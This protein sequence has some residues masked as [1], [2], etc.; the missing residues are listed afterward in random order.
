MCQN[1]P[2]SNKLKLTHMC[3]PKLSLVLIPAAVYNNKM[4]CVNF[5]LNSTEQYST[6]QY[7]AVQ[8]SAMNLGHLQLH[9]IVSLPGTTKTITLHDETQ[10]Q[11]HCHYNKHKN[12]SAKLTWLQT[13]ISWKDNDYKVLEFRYYRPYLRLPGRSRRWTAIPRPCQ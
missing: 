7:N 11:G 10:I 9:P 8:Y 4:F 5:L 13:Q 6:V 1:Q 12:G 3:I 2:S